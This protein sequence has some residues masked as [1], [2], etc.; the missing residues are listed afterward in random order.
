MRY[1]PLPSPMRAI[2]PITS[3]A[4]QPMASG[5][6]SSGTVSPRATAMTTALESGAESWPLAKGDPEH[7]HA[8]ADQERGPADAH[9]A[10]EV[11]ALGEHRPGAHPEI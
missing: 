9:A 1:S 8:Q 4:R 7:E 2:P 3:S 11:D 6:G 10:L 5:S